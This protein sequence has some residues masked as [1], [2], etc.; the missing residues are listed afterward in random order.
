MRKE[1]VKKS[2]TLRKRRDW[3]GVSLV[4]SRTDGLEKPSRVLE[5]GVDGCREEHSEAACLLMT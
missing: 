5:T 4:S 3:A 1:K 2:A